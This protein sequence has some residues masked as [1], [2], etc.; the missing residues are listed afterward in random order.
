MTYLFSY[1]AGS[2]PKW[3]KTYTANS[4]ETFVFDLVFENEEDRL[5]LSATEAYGHIDNVIQYIKDT[6]AGISAI[7]LE[8]SIPEDGWHFLGGW[9]EI[10]WAKE[11]VY[12]WW[13]WAYFND[14]FDTTP[15][16]EEP[17]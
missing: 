16:S 6:S 8:D 4:G 7:G 11:E 17:V 13:N 3:T 14:A 5:T 12:K 1:E 9:G 15:P 10:E 2:R